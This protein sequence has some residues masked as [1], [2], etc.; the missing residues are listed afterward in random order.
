M[1]R[2][3]M[4]HPGYT[5][6]RIQV[7]CPLLSRALVGGASR[8]RLNHKAGQARPT[9]GRQAPGGHFC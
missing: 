5:P 2:A 9:V 7:A 3:A 4:I 1:Q 8:A 6:G